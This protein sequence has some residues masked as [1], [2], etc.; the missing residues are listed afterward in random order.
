M[1]ISHERAIPGSLD[2]LEKW[3]IGQRDPIPDWDAS[4]EPISDISE[5]WE[6]TPDI[7]GPCER[8]K[9]ANQAQDGPGEGFPLTRCVITLTTLYFTVI[10]LLN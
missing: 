2:Q 10:V 4:W 8:V 6:P 1:D 5:P 9:L 7:P 3:P